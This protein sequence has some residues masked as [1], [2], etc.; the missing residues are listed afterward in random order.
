MI[1]VL[2][3]A[4][5]FPRT[6]LA[7]IGITA[8]SMWAS[9]VNADR[10]AQALAA[11]ATYP[12]LD[13]AAADSVSPATWASALLVALRDPDSPE[14]DRAVMAWENAEG[15]HWRNSAAYN[16][17]NTTQGEPGS[18]PINAVGVQAYTSWDEGMAATIATLGNG[19]YGG[20]LATLAAGNCAPCV[21]DAVGASP[22]GT[23][24]FA[25]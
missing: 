2:M 8:V 25:V 19:R 24:R 15:G 4:L 9:G 20:I 7:L 17:L 12:Q 16:P 1:Y 14:N 10:H 13:G 18:W 3:V 22:W 23:G 6:T 5:R 11:P 21:A